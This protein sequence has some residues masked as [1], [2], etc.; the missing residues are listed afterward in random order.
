MKK[1]ALLAASIFVLTAYGSPT[2]QDTVSG[3]LGVDASSA[4]VLSQTDDHGR[5]HGDGTTVI[6][7]ACGDTDIAGQIGGM[8]GWKPFPLDDTVKALVYGVEDGTAKM[9]PY[10]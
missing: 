2:A 9:G 6:V 7:L 4:E 1:I 8:E 10:L 5:F 3:E